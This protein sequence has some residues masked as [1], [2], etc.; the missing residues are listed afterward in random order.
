MTR[1]Q[2]AL[3]PSA[4]HP[5]PAAQAD[6]FFRALLADQLERPEDSPDAGGQHGL[7]VAGS[8][9]QCVCPINRRARRRVDARTHLRTALQVF[10]DSGAHAWVERAGHELRAS[11]ET[12]RH[13]KPSAASE[14][15]QQELHVARLVAEGLSN[16]EV[17]A[18][19]FVSPRTVEFHLHHVYGKLGV[20]SRTELARLLV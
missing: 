20:R 14:L 18:Q 1:G 6:A 4:R 17:A 3:R 8:R 5:T 9:R 12:V 11:G 10:S 15:T 7:L 19:L 2:T 13:R 16:R